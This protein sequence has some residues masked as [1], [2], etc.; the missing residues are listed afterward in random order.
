LYRNLGDGRFEDITAQSGVALADRISVSGAFADVDNDGDP[1]L[2]VTTVRTGNVLL[3]NDG[4]GRFVDV[5]EAAGLDYRGHSSSATFL[6]YDLDGRLDLLVTNVG[7]YTSQEQGRGGF[8]TAL[9]DAFQG[10][11]F[12]ERTERS[13]LY[14]NEDGSRFVEVAERVGLVER[15]WN[16]DANAIDLD[17]DRYPEIYV[18]SMQGDD[19]WWRN[20]EGQRFVEETDKLFPKT[21]WGA[22]GVGFFDWNNDQR[23]DLL[24]TDMHSDMHGQE[25]HPLRDEK[26]KYEVPVPG[27]RTTCRAT[28]SGSSSPTAASSR[29]RIGW[30]RRTT[31]PGGSPLV[32]STPT[33]GRTS[34]SLRA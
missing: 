14:R 22:M 13:L 28:P 23:L 6:D 10:H 19:H 29:S 18:V 16:G 32:T 5:T 33:G 7:V 9:P 25:V 2:F 21:P 24:V 27:S 11:R 20:V 26:R 12:P 31:G 8:W 15:G 17:R 3:L 34:S 30:G 4:A 1:D